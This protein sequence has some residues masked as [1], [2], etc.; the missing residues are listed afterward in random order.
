MSEYEN[1][2]LGGGKAKLQT[3][4]IIGVVLVIGLVVGNLAFNNPDAASNGVDKFFGMPSWAFPI[5]L[6]LVGF[7]IFYMGLKLEA[8][9]PEALG[10]LLIAAGLG[11]L[12]AVV[13]W[14]TFAFGGV[15][16]LPYVLPVAVFLIFLFYGMMK[17]R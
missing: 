13:G 4:I 7:G 8:D 1:K 3:Y 6:F 17:S 10:A 16:I 2:Y 5:V 15:F 9:W 14:D 11:M 12:E